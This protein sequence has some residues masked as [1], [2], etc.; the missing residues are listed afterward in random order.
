MAVSTEKNTTSQKIDKVIIDITNLQEGLSTMEEKSKEF[1]QKE[2]FKSLR[3]EVSL[4]RAVILGDGGKVEESVIFILK[5]LCDNFKS[6]IEFHKEQNNRQWDIIKI[7]IG[8]L[9]TTG[10]GAGITYL[11]M[12]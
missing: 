10:L 7:V 3:E 1:V 9:I 8:Y 5:S 2:D 4:L 12:K 6:H 11:F